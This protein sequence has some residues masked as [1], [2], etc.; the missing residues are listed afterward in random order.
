MTQTQRAV[1]Q[2]EEQAPGPC[3]GLPRVILLTDADVFAGTERHMLDLAR[4]LR[5]AGAAVTLACPS[6]SALEDAAGKEGL[7]FLAIQK[8]GLVDRAAVRTLVGLLRSGDADV[9]HTH[10]G[11]T[12]LSA[13]LAVRRAGL[14]RCVMT[15]HFLH[16]NHAT[17]RG[18]KALLS[19]L[20]HGWVTRQMSGVI[21]ISEAVRAAMLARR[22]V[23]GGKITVIPN[24]IAAPDAGLPEAGGEIRRSLGIAPDAPL[25]VCAARLEAEKDLASLVAAMSA[26]RD[27]LPAARCLIAGDGSLRPALEQQ[28]QRL[29]LT[30]AVHLLGFRS[31]ALALIAAADLFVLPSLAE[32]FGLAL[33]E[34]MALGKPVVATRAGGPLEIVE[35]GETGLLVPPS[36]PDDLATGIAR[37][38]SDPATARRLGE[39]GRARF[40]DRFTSDRMARATLAVYQKAV[41]Q[42]APPRP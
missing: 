36:S 16:P 14:G 25:L 13:A 17:Q 8:R 10:N 1:T 9:V 42:Q 19:G 6:P 38:L 39:N 20:A 18:P 12:A 33:L 27:A 29:G 21:A 23:P 34:A 7:P 24:G 31:D 28:V 15:Q 32:P 4:G 22:E 37:L 11:R 5:A 30:D 26:V 35:D 41:S 40:A 3:G 2:T